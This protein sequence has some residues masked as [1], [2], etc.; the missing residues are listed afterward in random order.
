MV[1]RSAAEKISIR[2]EIVP[3][4][5]EQIAE[6][7]KVLHEREGRDFSRAV[8]SLKMGQRFCV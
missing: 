6:N 2:L 1:S 7:L 5:A 4:A 8:K 3:S